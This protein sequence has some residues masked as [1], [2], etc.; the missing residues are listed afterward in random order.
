MNT[1]TSATM[2]PGLV[3]AYRLR[4]GADKPERLSD[5]T[6]RI[7]LFAE[8]GFLWLHLSLVDARVPAFLEH[9]P[10]L[11]EP[12]RTALTTHETHATITVDEQMLF[13]TLVDFQR[14]FDQDTR[15][16][17]W[18]HFV[19]TDRMLITTRLQPLRSV[20]RARMLI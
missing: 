8:D 16:I 17:G 1:I 4:P 15:D 13:G 14:E 11:N 5:D 10:G 9:A 6:D 19:L 20:E 2:I 7:K 12:A 18:L 3:W